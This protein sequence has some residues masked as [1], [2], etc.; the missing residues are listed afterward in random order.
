MLG[1]ELLSGEILRGPWKEEGR[2]SGALP[3]FPVPTK[4]LLAHTP[5]SCF[6]VG[7]LPHIRES[8]CATCISPVPPTQKAA[9]V[10]GPNLGV[11]WA[12]GF[13]HTVLVGIL[14]GAI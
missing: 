10:H 13:C 12:R 4:E 8:V 9:L 14:Q 11:A 1:W 5:S 7:G 3:C 2:D 6:V